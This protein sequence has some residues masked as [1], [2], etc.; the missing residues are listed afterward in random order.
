MEIEMEAVEAEFEMRQFEMMS[1]IFEVADDASKASFFAIMKIDELMD[2]EEA[3]E[4]LNECFELSSSQS[5]RRAIRMKLIELQSETD[6]QEAVE[7]LKALILG[8]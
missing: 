4:L 8:N 2:E 3:I 6:N 1:E 5:S 7:H